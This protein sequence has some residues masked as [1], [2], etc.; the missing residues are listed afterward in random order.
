MFA[1]TDIAYEVHVPI[2]Q[3]F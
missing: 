3:K 1:L 2:L